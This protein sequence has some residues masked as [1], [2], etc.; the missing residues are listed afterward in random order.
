[1]GVNEYTSVDIGHFTR[2]F[3]QEIRL[4]TFSGG[5]V[6][7]KFSLDSINMISVVPLDTIGVNPI[8]KMETL[9]RS[10]VSSNEYPLNENSLPQI[11]DFRCGVGDFYIH[12]Y[13]PDSA[14]RKPKLRVTGIVDNA[15]I[16]WEH[17][18]E[19]GSF[20]D[21]LDYSTF[22]YPYMFVPS[23]SSS[24]PC[25]YHR[26]TIKIRWIYPSYQKSI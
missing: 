13:Y 21:S 2:N 23:G 11:K 15:G 19:V 22:Y 24:R 18:L 8:L 4:G 16:D 7:C 6:Y 5:D 17:P 12:A 9:Y 3:S 1:M 25:V 26:F 20:S 14:Y 10:L